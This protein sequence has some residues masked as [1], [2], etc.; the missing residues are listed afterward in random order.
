MIETKTMY[1]AGH[2]TTSREAAV[3]YNNSPRSGQVR[4]LVRAMLDQ[5][6]GLTSRELAANTDQVSHES[7]H[8]RLPELERLGKAHRGEPRK[9]RVTGRRA[10]TWQPGPAGDLEQSE[11]F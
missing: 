9:C 4:T 11:L 2:P 1:K 6:P 5:N 7:F 10:T 3:S 8:K